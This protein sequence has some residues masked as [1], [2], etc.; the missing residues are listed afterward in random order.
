MKLS[1]RI[2]VAAAALLLLPAPAGIAC[3]S[4]MVGKKASSDGSVMTAH[5]CDSY[6]RTYVT[7]EPRK[8]FAPGETEPYFFNVL[9]KEEPWDMR[10][11]YETGRIVPPALQT[12]RFVNTAYPCMNE[13]Q[14]AIGETTYDGRRELINRDGVFWIEEL[15]RLALEYCD[16]ARD[17]IR[18]M[19][20]MAEK[21]GYA[22]WGECLTVAD[23]NEVWQFEINGPGPGAPGA[24]WA[25]QRIP[26]DHV[27]ISAN[28][29]RIGVIDFNDPDHFMYCKD[30]KKKAKA[31]GLWD[32][33]EP[34]KF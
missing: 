34:L 26:D 16:N 30:L 18:L 31:L 4:I 17:A 25:A 6:Y 29:S 19:G 8:T 14:L 27:G 5:C 21:Y 7:I 9:H 3:T 33:K 23:P 22:D 10:G 11:V 12:Y 20:E 28:I 32:G 1:S 13:K 24:I 15:E 2:L